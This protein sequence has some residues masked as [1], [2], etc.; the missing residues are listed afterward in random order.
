MMM[1]T[2]FSSAFLFFILLYDYIIDTTLT[3][4]F[5]I[6]FCYSQK[7]IKVEVCLKL[8]DFKIQLSSDFY[9]FIHLCSTTCS[10]IYEF[11]I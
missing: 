11:P 9:H 3:S 6:M 7:K 4:H 10:R 5:F 2:L 8:A 1:Y